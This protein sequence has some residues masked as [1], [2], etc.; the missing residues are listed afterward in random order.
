[1]AVERTLGIIKPDAIEKGVIGEIIVRAEEANLKMVGCK[2]LHLDK[3]R[4]E[5]FYAV[6]KEKPFFSNLVNFMTSG[7]CIVMVLE[8]E[9]AINKWRETMGITDP[10]KAAS[11][12][13]RNDFGTDIERNAVHGSDATETAN[14]EVP[15]FFE[16]NEIVNYEW[17]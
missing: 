4:A 16:G 2:M 10:E 3:P 11:G 7:P 5:G 17:V 15:Y 1:M 12:T 6:H 9:N 14:F 13:I 8:G